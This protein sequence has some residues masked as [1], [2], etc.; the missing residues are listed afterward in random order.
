MID[1]ARFSDLRA[2]HSAL[3]GLGDRLT[4]LLRDELDPGETVHA[5]WSAEISGTP[6]ALVLTDRR[7]LAVWTTR[8]LFVFRLP[9]QQEFDLGQIRR[10][11]ER[12]ADGLYLYAAADPSRPEE[13]YEENLFRLPGLERASLAAELNQRCP[14]LQAS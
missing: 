2:A 1:P 4:E 11:E 8:L 7:L 3:A 13:D 10:V 14:A 5:A 9:T 6:G 12:G